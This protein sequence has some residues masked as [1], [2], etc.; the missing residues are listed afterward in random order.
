MTDAKQLLNICELYQNANVTPFYVRSSGKIVLEKTEPVAVRGGAL[1][2]FGPAHRREEPLLFVC[3]AEGNTVAEPV[4]S[5]VRCVGHFRDYDLYEYRLPPEA[6]TVSFVVPYE[7][8]AVFTATL[9]Q[10]FDVPDFDVYWRA[11]PVRAAEMASRGVYFDKRTDSVLYQKSAIF[12]GD[13]LC[14]SQ[15]VGFYFDGWPGRIAHVNDMDYVNAG[16]SGTAFSSRSK[17]GRILKQLFAEERTDFDYVILEGGVN[18]GWFSADIG[19]MTEGFEGPFDVTTLAGA[20]EDTILEIRRRYPKAKLGYI[21]HYAVP[22]A[23]WGRIPQIS[24]YVDMEIQIAKKWGVPY[25]D[26]YHDDDFCYREL[27]V[28]ERIF[29]YDEV[30]VNALGYDLLYPKIEAFMESL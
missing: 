17:Y 18:D 19:T 3:D 16:R 24:D 1:L 27:K 29:M 28:K 13:S 26:L 12:F 22:D 11:E 9:D 25:L 6:A 23:P 14:H 7:E 4:V 20:L 30:H 10:P 8:K 2:T 21:L 15:G 5:E